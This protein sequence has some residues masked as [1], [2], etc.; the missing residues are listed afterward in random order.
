MPAVLVAIAFLVPFGEAKWLASNSHSEIGRGMQKPLGQFGVH[1]EP[2]EVS[3]TGAQV[4]VAVAEV[5]EPPLMVRPSKSSISPTHGAGA[6]VGAGS[7]P[8]AGSKSD[9]I[10]VASAAVRAGPFGS[11]VSSTNVLLSDTRLKV[12]LGQT[13]S[14]ESN[15]PPAE[16]VIDPVEALRYE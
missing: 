10:A 9:S 8:G 15:V 11:P 14:D 4:P 13:L 2:L 5:I 7:G 6:T 1:G 16:I 12:N 3:V